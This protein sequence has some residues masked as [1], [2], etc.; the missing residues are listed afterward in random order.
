MLKF[1]F[2]FGAALGRDRHALQ[3]AQRIEQILRRLR[4]HVVAHAIFGIEP[5][6]RR[7]LEG[8]TERHQQRSGDIPL[9]QS[10]VLR[11]RA[12]HVHKEPRLVERLLDVQVGRSRYVLDLLHQLLGEVMVRHFIVADDLNID[13]RRQAE[14]QDLRRHVDRQ[15]IE[16]NSGKLRE[17]ASRAGPRRSRS[18]GR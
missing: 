3:V 4:G 9:C 8:A 7:G 15:R 10:D 12:V 17:P 11:A 5:K 2:G 16:R 14:V 18:V 6:G 1:A 13:G